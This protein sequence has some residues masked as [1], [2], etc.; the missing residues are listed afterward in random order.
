MVVGQL[1]RSPVQLC[2][3]LHEAQSKADAGSTATA[4]ATVEAL[5][6]LRF[7]AVRNSGAIVGDADL[8]RTVATRLDPHLHRA[9][10]ADVLQGVVNEIADSLRQQRGVS[11][12]R[13]GTA[14]LE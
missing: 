11:G 12:N 2:N 6:H 7:V 9:P 13:H 4:V 14:G 3:S 1:E 10:L 5:R 8:D